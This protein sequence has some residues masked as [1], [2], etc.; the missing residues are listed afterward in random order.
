MNKKLKLRWVPNLFTM[1]NLT[2][3]F[4]SVLLTLNA[5]VSGNRELLNVAGLLIIFAVFFDGADGLAARLLKASSDLGA[6]LDSLADLTTFGIAPAVLSYVLLFHDMHIHIGLWP[7]LP[8]GMILSATYPAFAAYRLARF[9][10][11]HSTDH[12]R[13][14]PSPVAGLI[15]ALF[16]LVFADMNEVIL[17]VLQF[18]F[19]LV[20]V[21]MVSTVRYE[22]PQATIWKKYS[23][24]RVIAGIVFILILMPVLFFT[25][26]EGVA[27]ASLFT[28]A[29]VYV[30]TGLVSFL[31]HIIQIYRF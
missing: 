14:L 26:G 27:A 11:S 29:M 31:F 10:V 28:L 4:L 15:V 25:Y 22:K 17:H 20:G 1:V 23:R 16:P 21:L 12:F 2:F 3:G 8:I 9:N 13:G 30:V 24:Y 19:V 6:Q 18:M 5:A 7:P